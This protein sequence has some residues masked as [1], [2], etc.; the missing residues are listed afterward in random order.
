MTIRAEL[1]GLMRSVVGGVKHLFGGAYRLNEISGGWGL[2]F[3][4]AE[5][6]GLMRSV[7]GGVKRLLGG[8][9]RLNEISGGWG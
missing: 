8:A 3:F 2:A 6:I 9:Y 5:L 7:V 4:G 1:I